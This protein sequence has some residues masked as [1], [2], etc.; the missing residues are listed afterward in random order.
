MKRTYSRL[1]CVFFMAFI[2]SIPVARAEAFR[3][4]RG[5]G[6]HGNFG[7]FHGGSLGAW[8][9]GYWN[10]G[11]YG[12]NFGWWW[13]VG[14]A[15]YLYPAP[16]YPY[17]DAYSVPMYPYPGAYPAQMYAPAPP[18]PAASQAHVWYRCANPNGYYPYIPECPGGWQPMP[19]T[20]QG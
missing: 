10:H 11:W 15:W 6:G 14:G 19:A 12:N 20:P 13:V 3:G 2:L 4:G 16:I 18:P 9:G 7:G 5:V 1:L 8:R 17:P